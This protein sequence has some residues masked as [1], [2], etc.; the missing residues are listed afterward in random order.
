MGVVREEVKREDTAVKVK[1]LEPPKS[2]DEERKSSVARKAVGGAGEKGK[3][4]K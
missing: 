3:K 1:K 4:A 2:P